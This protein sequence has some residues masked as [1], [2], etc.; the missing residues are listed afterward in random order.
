MVRGELAL[1]DEIRMTKHSGVIEC[2]VALGMAWSLPFQVRKE[3]E[4]AARQT[5][6]DLVCFVG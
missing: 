4:P 2:H 1:N 6:A 3:L 5:S